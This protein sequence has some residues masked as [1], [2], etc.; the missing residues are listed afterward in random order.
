MSLLSLTSKQNDKRK[1]KDLKVML[2]NEKNAH[3]NT[4]EMHEHEKIQWKKVEARYLGNEKMYQKTIADLTRQNEVKDERIEE[5]LKW[6]ENLEDENNILKGRNKKD[7]SNSGKPPSTDG[8]KKPH[9]FSTREKSGKKPGGV[10][11]HTG[12]TLWPDV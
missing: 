7:S 12:H 9:V 8:F 11:G 6:I 4:K 3:R 2:S 10:N 1:I 5:L